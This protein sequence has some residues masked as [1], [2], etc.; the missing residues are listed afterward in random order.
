MIL[1]ANIKTNKKEIINLW[2]NNFQDVP[3]KRYEWIYEN[4]Q[5]G[6]ASCWLAEKNGEIVGSTALFPRRL[7]IKG[8]VVTG[9]IAGDFSVKREHRDFGTALSLQR[10]A[11]LNYLKDG[12]DFLYGFPNK[13]SEGVL[14]RSGYSILGDIISLTRLLRSQYFL[15]KSLAL[16]IT[17]IVSKPVDIAMKIFAKENLYIRSKEHSTEVLTS[18]DSRFDRFWEKALPNFTIIG[19]RSSSYLNWRFASSPHNNYSVFIT[20]Q[21]KTDDILGY[22][23]FSTTQNRVDIKDMLYLDANTIDILL[24]EFLLFLRRKGFDAASISLAGCDDLVKKMRRYGFSIRGRERKLLVHF[25]PDS[26][27]SQYFEEIKNWYLM[28]GDND[29]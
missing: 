8:Q 9:G 27:Y 20:K 16:P 26:C 6:E 24:S 15:K 28:A 11:L 5:A 23:I 14:K 25:L 18:F 10:E 22:I 7:F 21:T 2:N 17:R 19:E 1:K 4:N 13:H 3:V 12:F 29:I